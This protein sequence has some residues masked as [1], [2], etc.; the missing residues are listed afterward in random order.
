M[1]VAEHEQDVGTS[2]RITRPR[3]DNRTSRGKK[4][5][6]RDGESYAPSKRQ[7]HRETEQINLSHDCIPSD[8]QDNELKQHDVLRACAERTPAPR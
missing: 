4:R 8:L 5:G 7:L 3:R 1:V 2:C 6:Q